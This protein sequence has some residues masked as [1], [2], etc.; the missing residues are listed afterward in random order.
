MCAPQGNMAEGKGAIVQDALTGKADHVQ[1]EKGALSPALPPLPCGVTR[2]RG[3]QRQQY[4]C[5]LRCLVEIERVLEDPGHQHNMVTTE[6]RIHRSMNR[7]DIAVPFR[8]IKAIP[9]TSTRGGV[10]S[11]VLGSQARSLPNSCQLRACECYSY[12]ATTRRE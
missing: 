10:I 8:S 3:R 9:L 5:L 4:A 2:P 1:G 7:S 6:Y 11:D 12:R